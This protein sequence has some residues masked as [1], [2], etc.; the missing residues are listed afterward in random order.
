M[1][2]R[3]VYRSDSSTIAEI[4]LDPFRSPYA[5]RHEAPPE[6]PEAAPP[7][8]AMGKPLADAVRELV[9]LIETKT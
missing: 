1:V 6:Q 8:P 9:G 4:D 3:A 2:E 7:A 5:V